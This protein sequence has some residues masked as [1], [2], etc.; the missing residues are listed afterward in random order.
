MV[1]LSASIVN[2]KVISKNEWTLNDFCRFFESKNVEE[3]KS[4]LDQK[5]GFR[6]KQQQQQQ[7]NKTTKQKQAQEP[8][9]QSEIFARSD[10]RS[11]YKALNNV[12]VQ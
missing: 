4:C 6:S 7:K 11:D 12:T 2:Y 1:S 5:L 3:D 8:V 10:F 9:C